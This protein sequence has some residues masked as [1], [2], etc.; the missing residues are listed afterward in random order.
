MS[1]RP[2]LATIATVVLAS[3]SNPVTPGDPPPELT[4]LPRALTTAET[5]VRDAANQFSMLLW[6]KV[7]SA[8][9][10]K[11]VFISPL[12][13]SF[14]LGMTLNGANSTT[15]SEMRD[16]LQFEGIELPAI[17]DGYRSLI[18][19]LLSLD[20]SVQMQIANS[21]WYRNN[22]PFRQTF[23]ETAATYFG[24]TSRGLDFANQAASLAEI[25]G[26]V[27]NATNGRIPKILDEISP[28]H[29]MFLINAIYFKGNWR[30]AFDPARTVAGTF[31]GSNGNR[32]ASFMTRT[33]IMKMMHGTNFQAV[34]LPYGNGAFVMNV[35]L[36]AE[37][38]DIEAFAAALPS[39]AFNS[40]SYSTQNG[41]LRLPKL[42]LEYERKLNDDLKALGMQ[43]PFEP[44]NADFTN[45]SAAG[46][47]LYIDFVKQNTFVN[48]DEVG[49]E[50]AA[51]TNVGIGVVSMPPSMNVDRPYVFVL[52]ERL[53]G[54]ILFMG[55]VTDIPG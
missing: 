37:G 11:N 2:L 13:A 35:L 30:T 14:A 21:I 38:V 24:A 42:R 28:D 9:T 18:S 44:G 3:C 4:S 49:T 29:V 23:F 12:S 31:K 17:N 51:V 47:D 43:V 48:I 22:F 6:Q 19:L 39:S 46:R 16:A 55:K 36:P 54:T 52:R 7:N 10:R 20:S 40:E 26:W 15:Y 32:S 50:A 45:M 34:E 8:E 27:S 25:N 53:S 5:D 41:E 33:S 1:T